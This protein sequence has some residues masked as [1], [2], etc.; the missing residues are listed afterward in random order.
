LTAS[1]A[2]SARFP[3]LA[4]AGYSVAI[5][6][7]EALVARD[8]FVPA[9]LIHGLLVV[10]LLN[11]YL[12][13]RERWGRAAAPLVAL[14]LVSLLRIVS[15]T[16]AHDGMPE[17][18]RH[19]A[20]GAPMLFATVIAATFVRPRRIAL[21]RP[22]APIVQA[23]VA[24]SGLPLGYAAY[25]LAETDPIVADATPAQ[26][27]V[28]AALV[29]VFVGVMEELIFRGLLLETIGPI[30]SMILFA[31]VYVAVEPGSYLALILAAGAVFTVV[32]VWTQSAVGAALA[33]GAIAAGVLIVWPTLA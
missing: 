3:M 32:A 14:P 17:L 26:L 12:I 20:V 13:V 2:I 7:A 16:M 10:G 9:V 27:L 30:W 29:F 5:V 25:R 15:L 18:G 11:H 31:S 19:V 33:H 24:V 22:R 1:I 21:L 8:A 4:A 6:A 23:L 28:V